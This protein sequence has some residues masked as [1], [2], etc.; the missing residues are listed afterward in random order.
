MRHTKVVT[1]KLYK[2]KHV[3]QGW[4]ADTY[5]SLRRAL[6]YDMK[7]VDIGRFVGDEICGRM[8]VPPDRAQFRREGERVGHGVESVQ[9]R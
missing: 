9:G 5:E 8:E 7:F 3:F 6:E 4:I 2:A 1:T